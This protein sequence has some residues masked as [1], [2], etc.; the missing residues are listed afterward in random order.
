MEKTCNKCGVAK[1]LIDFHRQK[2]C[3]GGF[4][5]TCKDCVSQRKAKHY[6][7]NKEVYKERWAL[8][9]E[10][11]DRSE[12][13]ASYRQVNQEKIK[14]YW[15]VSKHIAAKNRAIRRARML[16]RTPSWLTKGDLFEMECIYK[17]CDSLR[18][19]GLKYEVDHI[20]PLAGKMVSGFHVPANLQVIPAYENRKKANK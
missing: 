13:Y 9:K 10:K 17:Y 3:L 1:P 15:T 11:T 7:K 20:L 19:I 6:S 12:Y 2:D 4:R 5:S 8:W 14:A 18:S 16:Q